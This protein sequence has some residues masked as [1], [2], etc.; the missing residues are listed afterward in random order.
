M[1]EVS[2]FTPL[3]LTPARSTSTCCYLTSWLSQMKSTLNVPSRWK[4]IL[5]Y[6]TFAA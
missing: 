1:L 3:I 4:A 6:K 2:I 5:L